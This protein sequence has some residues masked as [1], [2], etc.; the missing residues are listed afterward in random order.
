MWR[1][2]GGVIGI[3]AI[4]ALVVAVI[5]LLQSKESAN[6]QD[7]TQ[8]TQIAVLEKQLNV[9][10]EM[11]TFQASTKSA[12]VTTVAATRMIEIVSTAVASATVQVRARATDVPSV[13]TPQPL[14]AS[15]QIS[16]EDLEDLL[17]SQ[18]G[19]TKVF[20]RYPKGTVEYTKIAV[21][22]ELLSVKLVCP[23]SST[24]VTE[25]FPYDP[26]QSSGEKLLHY[27][28]RAFQLPLGCRLDFE[29]KDT[30]GVKIGFSGIERTTSP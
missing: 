21:D 2:I 4:L 18:R 29:I 23:S 1:K 7:L 3:V 27:K 13:P 8:A 14:S 5:Q 30:A 19:M 22:D 9:Q 11:A 20:S 12:P 17:P 16:F 25:Y 26:I 28:S 10:R 24:V 15:T 6:T